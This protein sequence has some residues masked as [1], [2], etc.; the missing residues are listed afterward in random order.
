[1]RSF[2]SVHQLLPVRVRD[3]G[4]G[5]VHLDST[6]IRD[7]SAKLDAALDSTARSP[8]G[9]G[10][11]HDDEYQRNR[12]AVHPIVGIRQK[13]S[14][15]VQLRDGRVEALATCDGVDTDGDGTVDAVGD[16][17]RM[18]RRN[19]EMYVGP[20]RCRSIRCSCR[21]TAFCA[22]AGALPGAVRA[23]RP[24]PQRHVR[25]RSPS[26]SR[27]ADEPGVDIAIV[28]DQLRDR[29]R[30]SCTSDGDWRRRAAAAC[31]RHLQSRSRSARSGRA[32]HDVFV[33]FGF[34]GGAQLEPLR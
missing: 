12:Y 25:N 24:R 8:A 7:R 3:A 5:L 18:D 34:T 31:V 17:N 21:S 4:S 27:Y 9:H 30:E 23:A 22:R 16:A 15:S 1:M 6:P 2:T 10:A 26:R 20:R 13:T 29:W 33:V 32:V 28:R 14:Q 11:R 19:V